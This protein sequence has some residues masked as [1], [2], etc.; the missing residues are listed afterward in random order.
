[1]LNAIVKEYEVHGG[2]IGVVELKTLVE[3]WNQSI[4]LTKLDIGSICTFIITKQ[5]IFKILELP[6]HVKIAF[7][8]LM[9]HFAVFVSIVL[10]D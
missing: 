10:V 6:I 8:T 5:D 9:E 2:V 3:S 1:M 7:H 4:N